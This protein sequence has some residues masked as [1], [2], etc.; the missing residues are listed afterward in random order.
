M[1]HLP[2][3]DSVDLPLLVEEKMSGPVIAVDDAYFLRRARRIAAHPSNR[4]ADYRLR[5]QLIRIEHAFPVVEFALPALSGRD[6]FHHTDQSEL[7]GIMLGDRAEDRPLL[8]RDL[9]MMLRVRLHQDARGRSLEPA[10]LNPDKERAPQMARVV[11]EPENF[12]DRNQGAEEGLVG[13]KL[14]LSIRVYKTRGR[15]AAQNQSALAR[16]FSFA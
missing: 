2:I 11:F 4:G 13:G 3:E 7:R 9:L 8:L 10:H 1:S 6:R 15:I 5:N 14:D 12:G 16:C